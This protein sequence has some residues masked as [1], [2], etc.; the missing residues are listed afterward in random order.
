MQAALQKCPMVLGT[1]PPLRVVPNV[2]VCQDRQAGRALIIVY[3]GAL[4]FL[5]SM[6]ELIEH[7]GLSASIPLGTNTYQIRVGGSFVH[8]S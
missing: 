8:T 7:W 5:L 2:T 3:W 1:L 6:F 4:K